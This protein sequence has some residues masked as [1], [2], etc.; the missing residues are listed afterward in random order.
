M[1]EIIE[2]PIISVMAEI[3]SRFI[4]LLKADMEKSYEGFRHFIGE[5]SSGKTIYYYLLDDTLQTGD[6]SIWDRI[7]PRA[8]FC[9][10]VINSPDENFE[11]LYKNYQLRYSTP[12]LLLMPKKADDTGSTQ[13]EWNNEQINIF[14]PEDADGLRKIITDTM[15]S[16]LSEN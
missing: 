11:E 1:I 5:V 10:L 16:L 12:A 13:T 4:P 9:I 3:N 14:D 8:P 15:R 6:Y 2:I 7:I